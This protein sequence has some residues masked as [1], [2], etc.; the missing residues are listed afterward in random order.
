MPK[1]RKNH[2]PKKKDHKKKASEPQEKP[3]QVAPNPNL[4]ED[5]DDDVSAAVAAY[6]SNLDDSEQA[7]VAAEVRRLLDALGDNFEIIGQEDDDDDPE[8]VSPGLRPK[9]PIDQLMQRLIQERET[10]NSEELY[11]FSDLTLQE[12]ETVRQQWELVDVERR[13]SVVTDLVELA[14]EDIDLDLSRFLR[15]VM[16]DSDAQVRQA[17]IPG[18]W[19]EGAIDLI[20]P[21]IQI[22]HNDPDEMVRSKAA[23]GLGAY[24]LAG[25]LEELDAALAMRAE[26]A[27]LAVLNNEHESLEVRRRALEAIA[28]S[29]EA[30]VRQLIEDGYYSAHEM[31]RVSAVFAM[32]R[33]ADV[34]WRG[35]VRAELKS[36]SPEMRAEAAIASGELG[37]KS[38]AEDVIGLLDDRDERV[39]LAAIFALGRI[40]GPVAQDALETMLL[41]ENELEVE[42]ADAAL[43]ELQLFDQMDAAISLFDEADEE[44]AEWESDAQ[45]EEWYDDVDD[46]LDEDDL[47]EYEDDPDDDDQAANSKTKGRKK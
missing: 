21:Y 24:I 22:L 35:L 32:G 12:A 8:F 18:L 20:G 9:V 14:Q 10:P 15:V 43:E 13:R 42:A 33:S 38:A 44:D 5:V 40:G 47:G 46:E 16:N 6:L 31:M 11:A 19:D 1:H 29:S 34:R 26:E 25:E 4:P 28:Y 36:P 23:T 45:D 7:V 2:I 37:A 41:S 30:G 39:R 27:L 3:R 17:A